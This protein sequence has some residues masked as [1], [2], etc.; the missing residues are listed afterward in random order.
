MKYIIY[1]FITLF[2]LSCENNK[3]ESESEYQN[4]INTKTFERGIFYPLNTSDLEIAESVNVFDS[5]KKFEN[6]L[7][8]E[9]LLSGINKKDYLSLISRIDETEFL[10]KEFFEFN[11][12]NY[13]IENNLMTS[14]FFEELFYDCVMSSFKNQV[15]YDFILT[16]KDK[17]QYNSYPNLEILTELINKVDFQS[18]TQRLIIPYLI[19]SNL[20][21]K[22]EMNKKPVAN[23]VY[24]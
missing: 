21:W 5:I 6:Y 11:S 19:Y 10:K 17:V 2:I 24:N 20:Y 14:L 13:F 18:E 1:I 4:C 12:D 22:Y 7:E 23:T 8:N 15:H 16:T 3:Y 9:K